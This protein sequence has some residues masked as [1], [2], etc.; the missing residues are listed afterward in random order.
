MLAERKTNQREAIRRVF[1]AARRPLSPQEAHGAACRRVPGLGIATVYRTVKRLLDQGYLIPVDIPGEPPRYEI[2]GKRHHHHF[3]C[4]GCRR[5][6]EVEGCPGELNSL[7]PKGFRLEGH[8][9][10]LYGHCLDCCRQ[11]KSVD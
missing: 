8:E 11:Q 7:T 1:E 10:V 9:V 3:Y 6:F 4:R 5:V 2:A